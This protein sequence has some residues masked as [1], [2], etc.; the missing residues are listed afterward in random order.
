MDPVIHNP[1][2]GIEAGDRGIRRTI[3]CWANR[4]VPI[5]VPVN[6]QPL[7]SPQW[8]PPP[9]SLALQEDEV[10][11]WRAALGLGR[12]TLS[13]LEAALSSDER[14]RAARFRF[15]TATAIAT[16]APAGYCARS[17]GCIFSD[18]RAQF[19]LAMR[20]KANHSSMQARTLHGG[21]STCL[22]P[23]TLHYLPSA[24]AASGY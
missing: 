13:R 5:K 4:G 10:H 17:S 8:Q 20:R 21:I 19:S 14:S 2:T 15:D 6:S 1:A 16:L 9:P 23:R 12:S 18:R 7:W 3:P 11:I 22:I 24:G